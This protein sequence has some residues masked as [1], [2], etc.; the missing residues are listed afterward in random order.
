MPKDQNRKLSATHY[1]APA[2]EK[3]L[4]VLEL[5]LSARRP[6]TAARITEALSRSPGQLFR[7]IQVLERRGFIAQSAD[8]GYAPTDRLFSLGLEQAPVKTLLELAIQ[9]MRRLAYDCDQSCHLAV[10]AGGDIVV[11]ARM[12]SAGPLGFSVRVGYRQSIVT[13][14]SGAVLYAFQ[15]PEIRMRWEATF[16][17]ALTTAKLKAFRAESARLLARGYE[18][19]ASQFVDG[20]TDVS[21]PITRGGVAVAALTIAFLRKRPEYL[22]MSE[23]LTAMRETAAQIS[24]GLAANDHRE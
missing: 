8:G 18:R 11:I 15:P 10:R 17:P 7:M 9:P 16:R 22:S 23:T 5:L 21:V 2:L 3:G 4:D 12:E 20:V 14:A 24:G 6:M 1:R 13:T 19:R